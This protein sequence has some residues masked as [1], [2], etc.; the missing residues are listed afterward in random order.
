MI[1]KKLL[2]MLVFVAFSS[3]LFAQSE[4]IAIKASSRQKGVVFL[5][6]NLAGRAVDLTCLES[7]PDCK[8]LRSREY[9]ML[10]LVGNEGTYNDCQNVDIYLTGA[11]RTREEP[12]GRY[13]LLQP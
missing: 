8:V 2:A 7:H 12:L 5:A 10:R 4:N 13:C 6:A 3:A 11:D 1:P 9:E